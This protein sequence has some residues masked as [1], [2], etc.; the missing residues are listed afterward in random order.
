[1]ED[2]KVP[3][4]KPVDSKDPRDPKN[5]RIRSSPIFKL[6]DKQNRS[7]IVIH[8]KD[9]GFLPETIIVEKV[10]GQNNKMRVSAV[11]TPEEMK[12]D[13]ELKIKKKKEGLENGK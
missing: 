3:E 13:D 10:P 5:W 9:F 2:L 4:K 12:K 6:K 1:M 8:L 11:L 7:F